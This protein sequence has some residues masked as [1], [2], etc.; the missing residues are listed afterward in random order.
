LINLIEL[1]CS[2]VPKYCFML[3]SA[4]FTRIYFQMKMAVRLREQG[5]IC[6]LERSLFGNNVFTKLHRKLRNLSGEEYRTLQLMITQFPYIGQANHL[7]YINTSVETCI[8]RQKKRDRRG[9][10]IYDCVYN[11][12]LN[13]MYMNCLET[14]I[15]YDII[16][17]TIVDWECEIVEGLE[18]LENLVTELLP[19][20]KSEVEGIHPMCDK[21][22]LKRNPKCD[23]IY[24]W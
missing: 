15:E 3:Q 12:Q 4:F 13:D 17:C 16:K 21:C 24:I 2:N 18:M 1:Y 11:T 23:C 19:E 9:E 7:I 8:K 22:K 10:D 5:I 20:H 6:I 14:L